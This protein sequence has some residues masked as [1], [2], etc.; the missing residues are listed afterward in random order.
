LI[1]SSAHELEHGYGAHFQTLL[2]SITP[3]IQ[4]SERF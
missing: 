2:E 1:F 3:L 4:T